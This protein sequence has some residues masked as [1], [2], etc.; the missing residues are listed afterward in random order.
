MDRRTVLKGAGLAA[1]AGVASPAIAQS[2]PEIRW[3]MASSYPKSLD[4]LF[5]A[6]AQVA[7]RVAE[8]TDNKFQIQVFAAGEIVQ[9]LQVMDAVQSGTV[10]CGYTLSSYYIG[11]DPTFMFET[12]VPWGL[13]VRQHNAWMQFGGGLPL[14]REFMKDYNIISFP[15]GQTGAQMGGWFRKEI[16]SVDDLKGLKFRI[17][18]M[19]GQI[20]QRLGVVPQ[21]LAGGD[22]YPALERGTLDA[23]EFSGP[24]D[25]EKLGFVKVAKYYYYPGFWEGSAQPS[26]FV[27]LEKW[28]A[29]P[30]HY[31]AIVE[32][33]CA[34]ANATC[35]MKYDAENAD[36]VR[37]LVGQGAQ[38]RAFP[39]D[40]LDASHKEA[41]KLYGEIAA[42]NEK[43]K[44]MYESWNAFREKEYTWFRIAE[45]PFDY[46]NYTQQ[47]QP[48]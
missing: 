41:F 5:G 18:G 24:Y 26:L 40:V 2:A 8:A 30:A 47:G 11:K 22:I 43:F 37:R 39:K 45:L 7:K 48:R 6:G 27:N 44:K 33:A 20:M 31:K 35:V 25:D 13:N 14:V 4:T 29:L 28:N 16:N 21:V 23:V 9:G 19:G 3:R 46:Y 32:L 42:G 15:A 1:A 36:A 12:S 38:L 34:E 17:A 10:E